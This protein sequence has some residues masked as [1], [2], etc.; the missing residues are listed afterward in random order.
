MKFY[1]MLIE[2]PKTGEK[3]SYTS[4]R[5]G[6]APSGWRCVGVLGYFEKPGKKREEKEA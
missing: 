4:K 2:N 5:Q 3:K 1:K 6:A